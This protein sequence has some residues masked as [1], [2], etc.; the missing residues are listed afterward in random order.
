MPSNL[1]HVLLAVCVAVAFVFSGCL[2]FD[3]S[4]TADTSES[5]VF[6]TLSTDEPWAGHYVRVTA[7]LRSTAAA[8]NVTSIT[9]IQANGQK[10]DSIDVGSGQTT[11][12]LWVPA[13]QNSTLV[14]SDSVNS[15]TLDTL[16]VTT[17]GQYVV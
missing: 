6:K 9:V 4:L 13:N 2:T 17:G 7:T 5:S 16:N 3:P 1:S 15:T 14:A 8:E 11:V 12:T 10:Y